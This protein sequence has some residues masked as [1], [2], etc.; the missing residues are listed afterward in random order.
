MFVKVLYLQ[1]F[2][3]YK[4]REFNLSYDIALIVGPNTSGKTNFM[5][6]VFFLSF[7]KSFRTDKDEQAIR[8]GEEVARLSAQLN[9]QI[10][11]EIIIA[12]G[13]IGGGINRKKY[14]VNGVVKR[15]LDFVGNLV[16]VLFSPLDLDMIVGSPILRRN[17]LNSVLEAVDVDYRIFYLEFTKA[18]RQRNALLEKA[19]ETGIRDEKQFEYWD[20]ILIKTGENVIQ[21]REELIKFI[22]N[23]QKEIFD[24][25][26]IYDKSIISKERLLQYK[27]QEL[28]AGV[29]LVGPQRDDFNIRIHPNAISPNESESRDVKFFG[30][31]G[32]QRLV[33]LQLKLLELEFIAQ[34]IGER[35][36]L[37]LD[38]IFSELDSN[39]INLVLDII[40]KQ[41]TI[42]TTTNKEFVPKEV[43][44]KM[45]T[46]ELRE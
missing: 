20:N 7:G 35:P 37:L 28:G 27:E 21:K 40:N 17:F 13:S 44:G 15:R 24:F 4:K 36:I 23:S 45:D 46:I 10:K 25:M 9:N 2:R 1:N 14:M 16:A 39:H 38:D 33:V 34:K 26:M 6:A 12:S 19:R 3:S 32:Q 29:T 18:L 43:L 31:R 11:L 30:S 42:I 5:E 8:F 22:N 41:Q